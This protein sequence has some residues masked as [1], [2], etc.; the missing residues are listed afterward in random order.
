MRKVAFRCEENRRNEEKPIK[1]RS[2]TSIGESL[3]STQPNGETSAHLI[4]C[5]KQQQPQNR[6][7]TKKQ[8]KT[9]RSQPKKLYIINAKR[10]I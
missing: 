2:I 4:N 3:F 5:Y 10:N 1:N 6:T 7:K 8:K 9:T